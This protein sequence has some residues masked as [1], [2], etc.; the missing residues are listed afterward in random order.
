V[1]RHIVV[2]AERPSSTSIISATAVIGLLM[3]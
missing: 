1:R 2:E 3:E